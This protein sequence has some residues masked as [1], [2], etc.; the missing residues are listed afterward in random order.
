[1]SEALNV[2]PTA[3][4]QFVELT[5]RGLRTVRGW[6]VAITIGSFLFGF[7]TGIISG[8]LLFIREEFNLSSFEQSSVV[9]VLLLGAVVGALSCGRIADRYGRR[10]LLAGLGVVFFVGIAAAAVANGYWM[11]MLGRFVMG[12][13]VGGVSATVPTYL[14]EMAPAQIRGRVLTLNQLLIS[15]GLLVS[16]LVNWA[17]AE[18]GLWRAMFWVGAVPAVLLV[19]AALRLPESPTWLIVHSRTA[20]ARRILDTVTEPGG[21]DKV[22]SR[23][24]GTGGDAEP[25]RSGTGSDSGGM[26]ALL[27]RR[28]RPA[29]L[30][31]VILAALQQFVGINTILY[32]APTIMAGVGLSASNAIYYSVF[33]G[34]INVAVTVVSVNLVD[35]LGRRPLLL[36]SLAGMGISIGMLGVAFAANLSPVIIL[37]FMLLYIVSFGIGMGP[38]FWV[39]LGELFPPAL[40]A[41]GSSAG[42]TINW[43]SNFLVS[44]VFLPLIAAIGQASTFWTFAVICAL[45]MA[46]VAKWVPET[47][48]RH[49][50]EVGRDLHRRWKV[51]TT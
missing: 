35:R 21:A 28:V 43:L 30:V 24:S 23:V 41:T 6:A 42:A 48:G 5:P 8:A 49:A 34:V 22:I 44:L 16:Y 27:A 2:R 19:L 14:G 1:M 45:G 31:G 4:S 51:P 40:R 15:V 18:A 12:L 50:D 37:I 13:A 32:Y 26:R 10:P 33:I 9:S 29:F 36:A 25:R 17:F 38:V 46:F 11:L 20:E 3:E 39:L 47:R 7:D